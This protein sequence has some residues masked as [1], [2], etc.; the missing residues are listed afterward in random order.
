MERPKYL[1]MKL[2]KFPVDVIEHYHLKDKVDNK[3][4][5][6]VK[7]VKG[8]YGLP[9]AGIIAQKLLEERLNKADYYQSDQTPG[10]WKHKWRPVCFSLIVDYFEVKYVG[11]EHAEHLLRTLKQD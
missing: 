7:Y 4:N 5:V 3:G 2:K 1:R 6:Y 10:F 8:M 9:H 11:I